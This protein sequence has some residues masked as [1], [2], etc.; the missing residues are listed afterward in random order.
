M[1]PP[2]QFTRTLSVA[3]RDPVCIRCSRC[4]WPA[5]RFYGVGSFGYPVL[6]D[7]ASAGAVDR[8]TGEVWVLVRC[9]RCDAPYEFPK[10]RLQEQ[11]DAGRR[12]LTLGV[13]L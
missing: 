11:I 1:H 13:D 8:V 5:R 10:R 3:R 7:G 12:D 9:G 2:R 6:L 4:R